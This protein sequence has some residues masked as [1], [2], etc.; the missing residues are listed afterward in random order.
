MADREKVRPWKYRRLGNIEIR[1]RSNSA[2]VA[3]TSCRKPGL[4]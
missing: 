2:S 4:R 1:S 3:S